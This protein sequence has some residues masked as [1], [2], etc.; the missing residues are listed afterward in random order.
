M[1][2]KAASIFHHLFYLSAL[3]DVKMVKYSGSNK[4][5][6]IVIPYLLIRAIGILLTRQID[7]IYL[8]DGLLSPLGIILKL[9]RRPIVVTI[10]GLDITYTNRLY[11]LIVPQCVGKLG[12]V[13]CISDATRKMCLDKGIPEGKI[14]VIPD[15]ISDEFYIHGDK[16]SLKEKLSKKLEIN[17]ENK[18]ILLS[19]GRLVERKGIHWF[20][21]NVMPK[22]NEKGND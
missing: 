12:K 4:W 19:V 15:G 5:L 11:Q 3:I 20:V 10:H 13:I 2:Y 21:E 14:T 16:Q 9:F 8:E 17:F 7:V 18:K 1:R 6:P 22:I